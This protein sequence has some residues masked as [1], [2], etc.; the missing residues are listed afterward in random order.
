M[1]S[2]E[3]IY[4]SVIS[5][6]CPGLFLCFSASHYVMLFVLLLISVKLICTICLYSAAF[7][8][9]QFLLMNGISKFAVTARN[10]VEWKEL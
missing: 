1:L 6:R 9:K 3:K 5:I 4:F 10:G 2:E 8:K 7:L